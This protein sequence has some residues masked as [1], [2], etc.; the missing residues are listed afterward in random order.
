[1][2]KLDKYSNALG[3]LTDFVNSS[4]IV[5]LVE[6]KEILEDESARFL[7]TVLFKSNN[8]LGTASFLLANYSNK[9]HFVD[10]L[11]IIVRSLISDY[12][13]LWYVLVVSDDPTDY[14]QE[15]FR[16]TVQGLNFDH[17]KSTMSGVKLCFGPVYGYTK[18]QIDTNILEIIKSRPQYFDSEGKPNVEK[19]TSS[20]R[21][22]LAEIAKRRTSPDELW[23]A[24]RYYH[25]YDIFSKYEHLGE[26]SFNLIHRQFN[27]EH[28]DSLARDIVDA[29]T[30]LILPMMRV[31]L[32]LFPDIY[33]IHGVKLEEHSNNLLQIANWIVASNDQL[34]SE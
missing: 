7:Y 14:H 5:S 12:A 24:Q 17:V 4:F 16:R 9:P 13:M 30:V 18:A 27:A 10:S 32:R 25:H 34:Q 31:A 21:A 22:A 11:V 20:V 6:N 2:E 33:K 15:K 23:L 26:F 3:S 19:V 29:I 1:M 28:K 8:G